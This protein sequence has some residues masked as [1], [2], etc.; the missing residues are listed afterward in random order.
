MALLLSLAIVANTDAEGSDRSYG[1][2]AIPLY[3][4]DFEVGSDQNYDLWPDGWTRR[5]GPGYPQYL[6]ISIHDA[7]PK[8]SERGRCLK[9]E[10]DGGAAYVSS[11]LIPIATRFSYA[12]EMD[13][14]IQGMKR[15]LVTM[16]L[17]FL[18]E[19]QQPLETVETKPVTMVAGW[20]RL[21]IRPATPHNPKTHSA[22]VSIHIR[23][24]EREDLT[25]SVLLDNLEVL[26]LPQM[27]VRSDR[28]N[29]LYQQGEP[30]KIQVEIS[31]ILVTDSV[32]NFELLNATEQPLKKHTVELGKSKTAE[33]QRNQTVEEALASETWMPWGTE[34]PDPGFYY[35]RVSLKDKEGNGLQRTLRLAVVSEKSVPKTGEFGWSLPDGDRPVGVPQLVTILR[36]AGVNWIKYPVWYGEKETVRARISCV[37]PIN[38]MNWELKPSACSIIPPRH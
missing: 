10:L 27:I 34:F 14:K 38:W 3:Q 36:Q 9:I 30:V 6:D 12:V 5:R 7:P 25:G 11:A 16:M 8:E 31:G 26:R 21:L 32:L 24:G 15:D 35:V 18:D 37:W 33:R 2:Q 19:N 29:A 13:I 1:S 23:P 22:V 4:C 17:T 20:Q 28:P